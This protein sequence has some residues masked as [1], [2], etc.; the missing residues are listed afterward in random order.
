MLHGTSENKTKNTFT[1]FDDIS[2]VT[3]GS[4]EDPLKKVEEVIHVLDKAG[5]K[6]ITEKGVITRTETEWLGSNCRL[7]G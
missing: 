2:I 4:R 1:I 7:K 6:I 3:K 5:N